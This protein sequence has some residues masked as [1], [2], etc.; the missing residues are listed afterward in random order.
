[1]L[2]LAEAPFALEFEKPLTF[3]ARVSGTEIA[4]EVAGV[5]LVANDS[6]PEA[7][8]S[9]GI[10]LFVHEGAVSADSFTIAP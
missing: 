8:R 9:G 4:A 10:G 2:I 6:S 3:S 5:R 1:M 7:L